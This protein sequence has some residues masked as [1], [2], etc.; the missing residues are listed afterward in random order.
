MSKQEKDNEE[1]LIHSNQS[2]W[3]LFLIL[4]LN[5]FLIT[6]KLKNYN[7][8]KIYKEIT[9]KIFKDQKEMKNNKKNSKICKSNNR[10]FR[11]SL[12]L[13]KMIKKFKNLDSKIKVEGLT[14]FLL[15]HS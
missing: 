13:N 2:T 6:C 1:V 12:N 5:H 4:I 15:Q 7:H 14:K 10:V 3:K 11:I 9:Q 8:K